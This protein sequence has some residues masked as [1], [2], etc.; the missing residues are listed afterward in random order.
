MNVA[1]ITVRAT[2]HVLPTLPVVAELVR[3]GVRVTYFTSA[4]FEKI[5]TLTG[6]RFSPVAT[7]LTNQGQAK[8]D[9]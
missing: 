6:A 1:L 4:N 3:R 2:G 5:I 7:V 9:I 8:D